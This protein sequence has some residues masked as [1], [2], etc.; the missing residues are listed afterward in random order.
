MRRPSVPHGV[1]PIVS[2]N[3]RLLPASDARISIFDRGLLYG[4]GIIET[5]RAYDGRLFQY[6]RHMAR[7]RH[8]A[9]AIALPLPRSTVTSLRRQVDA[10]LTAN[11]LR[12]ALI[13]LTV[14]R[15]TGP[16]G[17]DLPT[18][19]HPTVLI[20]ARPFSGYRAA[21]YRK[22]LTVVFAKIR[23]AP[24]TAAPP[25]PKSLN[26]MINIL[27][28]HDAS[29]RSADDALL[30]TV[31]GMLCEGTTSNLFFVRAGTLYTPSKECGLLEGITRQ[32]VIELAC[33]QR[34]RVREGRFPPR[35]LLSAQEAFL[36]NTSYELMPIV[37]V[38][39]RR[40]GSGLPGPLTRRLHQQFKQ[41][42]HDS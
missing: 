42:R 26:Y 37:R 39:K 11:R 8:S 40:I 2:L 5:L 3:G 33:T 32:L 9:Q 15:G 17:L 34:V 22:G 12:H 13:R 35:H 20:F 18:R 16:P 38:G 41:L 7:L 23:K 24:V 36:T 1:A 28:K 30:L 27:A 21:R 14:T 29:Q 25:Q 31:D 6:D 10:L 19:T 4:D